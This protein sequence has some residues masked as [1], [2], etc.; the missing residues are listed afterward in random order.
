M[1][2]D[3]PDEIARQITASEWSTSADPEAM[4]E[5][6][7]GRIS[8]RKV[9][10]FATA[11]CRRVVHVVRDD[12]IRGIVDVSGKFADCDAT[13]VD[14][15]CEC[16]EAERAQEWDNTLQGDAEKAAV[17]ALRALDSE[18]DV[19]SV[20][21]R[22]YEAHGVIAAEG[23]DAESSRRSVPPCYTF[24]YVVS[25]LAKLDEQRAQANLLRDIVGDPA[26]S[27]DFDSRWRTH[28]VIGLAHAIYGDCKFELLPILADALMD[29]GCDDERVLSHC[30]SITRHVRGCWVV[31]LVLGKT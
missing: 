18:L 7:S 30:R 11:C 13:A 3:S 31:D 1:S 15:A 20:V 10:L 2:Q 21:L 8:D 4:L 23:L 5:F 19:A 16:F 28:D 26:S 25:E 14:L 12:R 9:R 22:S 29:A 24:G 6:I 27:F 17:W